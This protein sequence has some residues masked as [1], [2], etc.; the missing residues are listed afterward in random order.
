MLKKELESMLGYEINE[1]GWQ[2]LESMYMAC[3][4]DKYEFAQLVK[5]GARRYEERKSY[6]Y[7][8][9]IIEKNDWT[10]YWNIKDKKLSLIQSNFESADEARD[11][12]DRYIG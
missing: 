4:L 12:I 3:D 1:T 10:G 5:Q 2:Q 8:G 11:L 6:K 9:Y 7:K